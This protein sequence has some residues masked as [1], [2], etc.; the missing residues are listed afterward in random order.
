MKDETVKEQSAPLT[1][2]PRYTPGVTGYGLRD[3]STGNAVGDNWFSFTYKTPSVTDSSARIGDYVFQRGKAVVVPNSPTDLAQQYKVAIGG[4]KERPNFIT[5]TVVAGGAATGAMIGSMIGSFLPGVGNIVGGAVGGLIGGLDIVNSANEQSLKEWK[6]QNVKYD[7]AVD[8][9]RDKDGVLKYKLDYKKMGTGGERSGAGVLAAQNVET[10]VALGEDGR[11][12]VTVSPIYAATDNFK[13]LIDWISE[14]YAGLDKDTENLQ[15]ILDEIKNGIDSEAS[16]YI[17]NMRLYADYANRFPNASPEAVISA[18]M[19]EASGY[20]KPDD[21]DK[22]NMTVVKDGKLEQ[23]TAADFFDSFLEMNKDERN[24][25]VGKLIEISSDAEGQYDDSTRAVAYGELK[26]LF[27]ASANPQKYKDDKYA[28]MIDSDFIVSLISHI[29]PLSLN[30]ADVLNFISGG[31]LFKSKQEYL[32]QNEFATFIGTAASIYGGVKF[33][34]VGTGLIEK[35]LKAT[36]GLSKVF[37]ASLEG[38]EGGAIAYIQ[39]Y[40]GNSEAL[41]RAAKASALFK[42]IKLGAFDAALAGTKTLVSGTD[43]WT[44]FGEDLARDMILEAVF[45]YYDVIKIQAATSDTKVKVYRDPKTGDIKKLPYTEY[46]DVDRVFVSDSGLGDDVEETTFTS[47]GSSGKPEE[48]TTTAS[49][50]RVYEP[51]GAAGAMTTRAGDTVGVVQSPNGTTVY[52]NG[53]TVTVSPEGQVQGQLPAGPEGPTDGIPA[54]KTGVVYQPSSVEEQEQLEKTLEAAGVPKDTTVFEMPKR[55]AE[56]AIAAGRFAKFDKTKVG[57]LINKNFFNKNA[58]LDAANEMALSKDGDITGW[59]N[60]S[61]DFVSVADNAGREVT[62]MKNGTYIKSSAEAFQNYEMAL[63]RL[64]YMKK[65]NPKTDGMYLKALR[66]VEVA[67]Y[68]D[69]T[70][71]KGDKRNYEEEALAK[72]GDILTSMPEDRAEVLRDFQEKRKARNAAINQSALKSGKVDKENLTNILNSDMNKSLGWVPQWSKGQTDDELFNRFFATSQEKHPYKRW[73]SEGDLVDLDELMDPVAADGKFLNFVT[74]NMGMNQMTAS[75][76][77]AF[78]I[79]GLLVDNTPTSETIRKAKLKSIKNKDELEDKMA[80]MIKAKKDEIKEKV[81]SPKQYKENMTKLVED[82][83]AIDAVNNAIQALSED[84]LAE[85]SKRFPNVVVT[86]QPDQLFRGETGRKGKGNTRNYTPILEYAKTYGDN[87]V[88]PDRELK[89]IRLGNPDVNNYIGRIINQ[90]RINSGWRPK[91]SKELHRVQ[92]YEQLPVTGEDISQLFNAQKMPKIVEEALN[93]LGIDGI[94]IPGNM[95]S[96]NVPDAPSGLLIGHQTEVIVWEKSSGTKPVSVDD[97]MNATIETTSALL[98]EAAKYNEIFGRSFDVESYMNTSFVPNLKEAINNKSI[99]LATS[100]IDKAVHDVAPY[101]SRASVYKSHQEEIAEEWRKWALKNIKAGKASSVDLKEFSAEYDLELIKGKRPVAGKVKHALWELVEK[102]QKLPDSEKLEGLRD[103]L[104]AGLLD[105]VKKQ[106]QEIAAKE[107][108]IEDEDSEESL[109]NQEGVAEL[110]VDKKPNEL[111]VELSEDDLIEVFGEEIKDIVFEGKITTDKLK[112]VF[113]ATLDKTP[114]FQGA[115]NVKNEL[116]DLVAAEINGKTTDAYE[117]GTAERAIGLGGKFPISW[118]RKGKDYTRFLKYTNKEEK[119][120]AQEAVEL[121]SDSTIV[122]NPGI[123]DHIASSFSNGFRLLMTGW[124][125]TRSILNWSRDTGRLFVTSEGTSMIN[126]AVSGLK[127]ALALGNYSPE[128]KEQLSKRIDLIKELVSGETYNAAYRNPRKASVQATKNYLNETGANPLKRFH[129]TLWHTPGQIAEAPADF[130][131]GL[132]RKR[133]AE[134]AAAVELIRL[135]KAGASFEEQ[136]KGMSDAAYYAGREYTA[137]F[138]RK[139]KLIGT[140]SRYVAYL[141]SEYAG[142]DGMKR[143]YISNPSAFTK[144]FAIFLIAYLILLADT[145]SDENSRKNYYRLSDWDRGNSIVISVGDDSLITIPVDQELASLLF[146]YRRIVEVMNGVDPVSF[147]EFFWGTVTEPLPID[148]S[149]FSEGGSFNLARG[150]EK[151]TAQHMPNVL[152]GIQEAATG[153][154]LY[155]GSDLSVREETLKDYGIYDPSAGD[156]TTTG[157]D[158]LTLRRI[159][160]AT[161]IQQW[162]LQS[163][164]SNYGANVGGYVLN[165]IDKLSG[166]TKEQQGGKEFTD[167]IFKSFVATDKNDADSAFYNGIRQLKEEKKKVVQAIAD[168]NKDV[169]TANNET[170]VALQEKLQKAK[171]DFG[172]K[173]GDFVDKYVS[174]YEITGGLPYSQAM[175]I[176]YLFRFDDDDTV[177]QTGSVEEYHN[178]K[179]VQQFKKQATAMS[180]PILDKYYTNR[181]GNIYLDGDGNWRRYLSYGAQAMKNSIFGEGEKHMVGLANIIESADSKLSAIRKEIKNARNAAWQARDYDTRDALGYEFDKLVINAI[182]PY[183]EKYGAENVLASD[184]VLDYLA[185]WFMVPSDFKVTKKGKFVSL[186]NNAQ[187]DEAFVRPFIKFVFGL[188]TGYFPQYEAQLNNPLEKNYMK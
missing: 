69:L 131:E 80:E 68:F 89:I 23:T 109:D 126:P 32:N 153:Y 92:Q 112:K 138:K 77:E 86:Y 168:Y 121:L 54:L 150:L 116:I 33:F 91:N 34:K 66:A 152:T 1:G 186:G 118:Y 107:E 182:S 53:K 98:K 36:P 55:N 159:A 149:G 110:A 73:L 117:M 90:F 42:T 64:N 177:Y 41:M 94:E 144:S 103:E 148:L 72:Y 82:S 134:S 141:S 81:P 100:V 185:E 146:P 13:N 139:G 59:H 111:E 133:A 165:I 180:A 7:T 124:D 56:A 67:R 40:L 93:D 130:F 48:F 173:V 115:K 179:V 145:L 25:L 132:S 2:L 14:N 60:R 114:L 125:P 97:A 78:E 6:E 75:A 3:P 170:K 47:I 11:L 52:Y 37:A 88:H 128:E 27:A 147:F 5:P 61:Q 71:V 84:K 24:D 175:Q 65:Y 162:Q 12:K 15:Q 122:K 10:Q 31:N 70:K 104:K 63:G 22:R 178:D 28:G 62:A 176:Y 21:M 20:I 158:S 26:A 188:S 167:A 123:V 106:E 174:A 120:L 35:V 58:I 113:Y 157:N 105:A 135:Q 74:T 137:N 50:T 142:F 151:L 39:Q 172:T 156:Y 108:I 44:E 166:A 161:G 45:S 9:Y 102:G 43:F 87:I 46:K 18:Y 99:E 4:T 154:D 76:I 79:A 184:D 83:G 164:V 85:L 38:H 8:F 49:G 19:T 181:I 30:M 96:S 129:Y 101:T 51:V 136:L 143:A 140:V 169:E 155:Y 163:M 127:A 17:S 57:Q 119:F 95:F 187:A 160:D 29:A 171:D 16:A 183:I